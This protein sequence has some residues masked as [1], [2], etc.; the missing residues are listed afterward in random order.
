MMRTIV[1]DVDDVL[2]DLMYQ[3]FTFAW[4]PAH[5]ECHV[6]YSGLTA[7]PPHE[8]LGIERSGYLASLDVFRAT[9][10]ARS[11]TPSAEILSWFQLDG[12]RFRH[13]ALSARPLESAPEVARWVLEHFGA[14]IRCIGVVP[15]RTAPGIPAYDRTKADFLGWL[16]RGDILIDDS[17]ENIRQA[18]LIGLKTLMPRQPWNQSRLTTHALL[19][20]LTR[21]AGSF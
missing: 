8:A 14:W 4:L 5:P 3:W 16:G 17:P 19:E 2:N 10:R 15:T 21:M 1:W 13:L 6:S 7:N 20:D 11:M 18:Q 9:D 12:H